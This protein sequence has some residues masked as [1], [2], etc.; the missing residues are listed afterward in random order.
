MPSRPAAKRVLESG[1]LSRKF[2]ERF[3][4]HKK[5]LT[6]KRKG[7]AYLKRVAACSEAVAQ[8]H[9]DGLAQ[10]LISAGIMTNSKQ[11]GPGK[12]E[13]DID[14]SRVYNHDETPQF[15]NY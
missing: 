12:W 14:T 1:K 6:K 8:Q 10:E 7:A 4:G 3:D 13:G 15:L 2:F 9:I 11:I 5:I